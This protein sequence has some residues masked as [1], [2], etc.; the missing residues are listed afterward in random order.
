L[1]PV[2]S[3][4][5]FRGTRHFRIALGGFH[6]TRR[7]GGVIIP[8][9]F[10]AACAA[11]SGSSAV[12]AQPTFEFDAVTLSTYVPSPGMGTG[13]AVADFDGDDDP[14]IFVPTGA[15]VPNLLLRNRGDGTFD[16]VA[17]Q[18]GLADQRQARVALWADYDGDGDLDLFV[19]RDCFFESAG[20]AAAGSCGE[21]SLSLFEQRP[22]GFVEV[23][24]AVGLSASAGSLTTF[25]A[26]GL[27]AG[28]V[29]GD[30][31]PDIYFARWLAG[32]EL[33]ISDTLFVASEAPG[34]SLGS[35]V[36][37]I[38]GAPGG[39]WQTLFHDFDGDGRLD[40]FVNVDFGANQLWMNGG[41]LNFVDV[42]PAAGV[43]SEWNEMG[44]AVGDY[45]NDGD[46]DMY[47]T[48]IHDWQADTRG[49]ISRNRLFRN[50]SEPGSVQ[51]AD[52]SIDNGVDNSEW[53]WGTTWL[54]AD[55]DGD[56]DLAATN[57]YCEPPPDGYCAPRHEMDRSRFFE[58][59]GDGGPMIEVGEV[60]GF[61][62]EL[63]GAGLI[64]A[65]FDGDGR[66]DLLQSAIDPG[67]APWTPLQFFGRTERLTLYLNRPVGGAQAGRHVVIR[68]RMVGTN[69]R[70][71]GAVVR[72][73]LD[74][75]DVL[76]RLVQAGESW[77][78]QGPATLHFGL[79]AGTAIDRVEIDWPDGSGTSVFTH[80]GPNRDF[81]L[82]GPADML[83]LSGFE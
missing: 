50:D 25:H 45:D 38:T 14:D 16:E 77:M 27:S 29:S 65:D 7:R 56:L 76:T 42:A 30:G 66:Q 28:D 78:S 34:Y 2:E 57:G 36:T 63:I 53:G 60:V 46:L 6:A 11:I 73:Y 24:A 58:N 37:G 43:D 5:E 4:T 44:L 75:G 70:A 26:G 51:F 9:A 31:L 54:D 13:I 1:K 62:D 32:P 15:G 23:S 39:E 67:S 59:P 35:G 12:H 79:G 83:F 52:T 74:S 72:M 49:E 20:I 69:S 10:I 82:Y 19:G 48:N 40:L 68:P 55:N 33:Y 80:V 8:L 3:I 71:V 64:A 41:N 17:A 47:I 22:G 61:D 21:V 18:F 81:T